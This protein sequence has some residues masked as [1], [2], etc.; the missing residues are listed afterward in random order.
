MKKDALLEIGCEE[1]PSSF[2]PMGM[3]QLKTLA[4]KSFAF[5]ETARQISQIEKQT[6]KRRKA[7]E[8]KLENNEF[9]L[10]IDT[11]RGFERLANARQR[12]QEKLPN[13]R[14]EVR[15]NWL[16]E[17][18]QIGRI[19]TKSRNSKRWKRNLAL[20]HSSISSMPKKPTAV[21]MRL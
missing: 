12:L 9:G 4:E 1:L 17:N 15:T 8:K 6:E 14:A 13:T 18:V 16:R 20:T 5:R 10:T 7:I 3:E 19:V 11:V 2:V 21:T